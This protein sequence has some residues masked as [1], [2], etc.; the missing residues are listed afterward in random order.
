M[1]GQAYMLGGLEGL[2][3][4]RLQFHDSDFLPAPGIT[5][6]KSKYNIS[7]NAILCRIANTEDC[8]VY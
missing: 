6:D 5:G 4:S 1:A 2:F 8:W 3:L 7:D